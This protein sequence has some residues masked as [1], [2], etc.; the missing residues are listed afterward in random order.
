M[1]VQS[2][3][4]IVLIIFSVMNIHAQWDKYPTYPE[5]V[6]HMQSWA[7]TYPELAKLHE[8]GPSGMP[9]KNHHVYALQISDNVGKQEQEPS[10]LL[11][12]TVH[13]DETLPYVLSLHLIDHL[14]KNYTSDIRIKKIVDN[15]DIWILPLCNPDGTYKAGDLT[16]RNAQRLT[17]KDNFDINRNFPCFCGNPEH[18]HFG[19]YSYACA[20]VKAIR[21][22]TDSVSFVIAADIHTSEERIYYP[23]CITARR[24]P[25]VKW[26]KHTGQRYVDLAREHG[27]PNYFDDL[28]GP[29]PTPI[30]TACL[31]G[32]LYALH[33]TFLDYL[34]YYRHCKTFNFYLSHKKNASSV[35]LV[36]YWN[37][38]YQAL[39]DFIE[40]AQYGLVGTVVNKETKTPLPAKI[41]I[42]RHDLDSSHV[43]ANEK[44]GAFYRPIESGTYA[45][46]VSCEG[47]HT[48]TLQNVTVEFG[49]TTS[50]AI[51]LEYIPTQ[52]IS[53]KKL[54]TLLLHNNYSHMELYDLQG[55]KLNSFAKQAFTQRLYTRSGIYILRLIGK[56]RTKNI[57]VHIHK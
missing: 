47:Y 49:K 17:L 36:N 27:P 28:G 25:D 4:F 38:N 41:F 16:V 21:S 14:L 51:E 8:L 40:Q 13:G 35:D 7:Q 26:F 42:D 10:I 50:L 24:H 20:E 52:I 5:Y 56:E 33:G 6:K 29:W 1:R 3:L 48:K 18:Q 31:S 45:V 57:R 11:T 19:N 39:L 2:P 54:P 55:R 15:S 22:L 30:C 23:W 32:G 53:A 43:F 12:A 44:T 9:N 34:T 37:Y 46:I